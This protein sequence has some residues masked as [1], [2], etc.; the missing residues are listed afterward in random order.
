MPNP[1][2][3]P[4]FKAFLA[5]NLPSVFDNTLSYYE[6]LTKL[7][8]YLEQ[9]VVPAV[10]D[11]VIAV[12]ALTK[13][14][15]ELKSYVEDY[16]KNLDVQEEI[17]VKLDQMA[18]DGTLAD[19]ISQYLNSTAVFGYDSVT[20]MKAADNLTNGSFATTLGYYYI[21]D[22]G[23]SLYKIRTKVYGDVI[24]EAS[25]IEISDT[26]VAELIIKDDTINI[27]QFGA[28]GDGDTDDT[29]AIR[30]A[31]AYKGND[32]LNII[33]NGDESYLI[34]G[35]CP[36]YSNTNI[37]LNGATLT[38]SGYGSFINNDASVTVAGY[39]NIKNFNVKNGKLVG[40]ATESQFQFNLFHAENCKFENL[41][42]SYCFYNSHA[43]DLAGCKGIT[44]KDCQF[45]GNNLLNVA[46]L[47]HVEVIQPDFATFG[48]MPHWEHTAA[49]DGLPTIDML[50]E[51]CTFR[52]N[53]DDALNFNAIGGHSYFD[54]TLKNITIRD[55][56]F[57]GCTVSNIRLIRVENL[58]IEN[59]MFYGTS[60]DRTGNNYAINCSYI[61]ANNASTIDVN[62]N[63][64]IIRNN[65]YVSLVEDD[66]QSFII[67]AG[68][69][70]SNFNTN[71]T[72][73]GNEYNGC[74]V[75]ED[76][77]QGKDFVTAW[78]VSGLTVKNNIVRRAKYIFYKT[79]NAVIEDLRYI[80]NTF[81]GCLRGMSSYGNYAGDSS[82]KDIK[83]FVYSNNIWQN[84]LGAINTGSFTA[85]AV[86]QST[87]TING[88]EQTIPFTTVDNPMFFVTAN[89]GIRI[90]SFIKRFRIHG[91]ITAQTTSGNTVT[92][93][94]SVIWDRQTS[95]EKSRTQAFINEETTASFR[96]Y[97]IADSSLT[98][99]D[100]LSFYTTANTDGRYDVFLRLTTSGNTTVAA[101]STYLVV[102]GF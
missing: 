86:L 54:A 35:E 27:K 14:V 18:E 61:D 51:N 34:L 83:D 20:D 63:G 71:I 102:E 13:V 40:T 11:N 78:F 46:D 60:E 42:F 93:A 94:V 62:S 4:P 73:E 68:K 72:I 24:D 29:N 49:F 43:F 21:N 23:K 98:D 2:P 36:I 89:N 48:A 5:S 80:G 64:I 53:E 17:N 87:A 96:T 1:I 16:F 52:K 57:Y 32:N 95:A 33:F 26:L 91:Q 90:P 99:N 66:D 81:E 50:V 92:K 67:I 74:A 79:D 85:T 38:T 44:I 69:N 8:A 22:G 12:D 100:L 75:E 70:G 3:L 31:L 56:E 6:E 47:K 9:V 76:G 10:N 19:I 65:K 58:L 45:I 15:E 101:T 39:G 41:Y 7:I 55:C 77:I 82:M 97:Q 84:S 25:I 28:V 59:N 88:I 37:D 30:K